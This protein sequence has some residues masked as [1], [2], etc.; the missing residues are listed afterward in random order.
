MNSTIRIS[1]DRLKDKFSMEMGRKRQGSE[2]EYE[3]DIDE[4]YNH[5]SI[6]GS[7]RQTDPNEFARTV[8]ENCGHCRLKNP[9]VRKT[10]RG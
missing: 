10:D 7:T 3:E 5:D 8:L 6:L 4:P 2:E 1:P 9:T